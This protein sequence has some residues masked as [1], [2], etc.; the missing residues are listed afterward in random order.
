M[1]SYREERRADEAAARTADREDR[2][3]ELEA[4]LAYKRQLA[5][6]ERADK[7]RKAEQDRKDGEVK[8]RQEQ[9]EARRRQDEK[10]RNRAARMARI[11]KVARWVN[12][13]PV[14][15]FVGFVMSS[16]VIPAVISQVGA[17]GDTGVNVLLAALLAA[18]L[19]GGAWA[20]TFMGKAAEDAGR[21]AAKYRIA[22]W[23][24]A[25]VA[26][27]VNYWHWAEKL[28]EAQ[29]VA[30]VFAASSLFA[31]YLWDMKTHGSHGRTKEERKAERAR[32][33]HLAKRKKDHKDIAKQAALLLSA[34][35]Y[36]AIDEEEAFAA[37]WRIHKGAEP[38]LSPELY[39]AATNAKVALGAA[40]ELGE[41]VRPEMVRAGMLASLYNP[42]NPLSHRPAQSVPALNAPGSAPAPQGSAE[43]PAGQAG[44]G[45]YGTPVYR[46]KASESASEKAGGNAGGDAGGNTPRGRSDEELAQLLP[47][48]HRL[49]SELVAEGRQISA[50]SLAKGLKIRREDGMWLRDR[51]IE[52]RKLHLVQGA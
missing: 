15:V 4:K 20:F 36:G 5:E 8:R 25:F 11:G 27:A 44:I 41:H 39:A 43:G 46:K 47:E 18:M 21:P 14:T 26:A 17:L 30:I 19:E 12:A 31:I 33:S 40:F 29:W 35:P 22:T 10:A 3:L 7:E 37:A 23:F 32:R 34:M 38:G 9:A 2:R 45:V 16:S 28:P 24:T 13:N 52:E 1:S 6:D 49:A 51:V 50:A 48:A 42:L